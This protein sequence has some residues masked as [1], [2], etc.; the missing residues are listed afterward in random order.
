MER[1]KD[2]YKIRRSSASEFSRV[3]AMI[4][5]DVEE[6]TKRVEELEKELKSVKNSL[7]RKKTE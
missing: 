4:H 3:T 6:L 2:P 1:R 7:K 5:N